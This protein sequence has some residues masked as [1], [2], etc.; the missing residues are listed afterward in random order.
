MDLPKNLQIPHSVEECIYLMRSYIYIDKYAS[1][2]HIREIS[3]C[4]GPAFVL[5]VCA[6]IPFLY[7]YVKPYIKGNF[8]F[9]IVQFFLTNFVCHFIG[10][11]FPCMKYYS[12][13]FQTDAMRGTVYEV[14]VSDLYKQEMF[15]NE[16]VNAQLLYFSYTPA[17][18]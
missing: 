16:F 7:N 17:G 6:Q 12:H 15:R 3:P 14:A 5:G 1:E 4:F 8:D 10:F 9:I 18:E 2:V 11:S 13:Q